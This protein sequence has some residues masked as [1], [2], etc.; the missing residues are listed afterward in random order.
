MQNKK[1]SEN[2]NTELFY[3]YKRYSYLENNVCKNSGIKPV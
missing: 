3:S 2:V 1:L